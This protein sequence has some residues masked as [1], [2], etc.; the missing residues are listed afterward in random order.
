M[1]HQDSRQATDGGTRLE[2][3]KGAETSY[4]RDNSYASLSPGLF[5]L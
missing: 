3:I 2:E 1:F 5:V 4:G